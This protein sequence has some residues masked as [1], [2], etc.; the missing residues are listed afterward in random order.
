MNQIFAWILALFLPLSSGQSQEVTTPISASL[1]DWGITVC[2]EDIRPTG[3]TL[4]IHQSG[5]HSTG[6]L[7]FGSDY[8]LE[9]LEK[10]VWRPVPP[11]VQGEIY[12]D[13]LAY[14]V[15]MDGECQQKILW[16]PLYGSLSSGTYR[17]RKSFQ[18]FRDTGDFDIQTLSLV[19]EIE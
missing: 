13:S 5:G 2:A 8:L 16:E 11:T 10:S 12:W 19:F 9:R 7:Q 3:L 6:Q 18:D 15:T 14:L 4:S 17:I 1:P